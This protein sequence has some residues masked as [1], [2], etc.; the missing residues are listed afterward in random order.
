MDGLDL[1]DVVLVGHSMGG[2]EVV[3]YLSRYR[4]R[5]VT[6]AVLIAPTTPFTMRTDDNPGGAHREALEKI[7]ESLKH[8]LPRSRRGSGTGFFRRSQKLR[9]NRDHGMVVPDVPGPLLD[10]GAPEFSR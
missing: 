9:L 5:R 3:R 7:R 6:H 8:D 2:A 4:S 1:Q 10:Q